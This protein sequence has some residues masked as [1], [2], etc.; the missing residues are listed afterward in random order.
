[1][2]NVDVLIVGAGPAGLFLATA[3]TRDGH[4]LFDFAYLE[5]C[6]IA[7]VIS[8]ATPDD[9]QFLVQLERDDDPLRVAMHTIARRC[10]FNPDRLREYQLALTVAC[11]GALK[12]Y[13]L[14]P[15]QKQR[16]YLTAAYL[17]QTL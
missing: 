8:P 6:L 3:L 5:A 10:L 9:R 7:Q 16:L 13:N 15:V 1:M 12:F 4:A 14:D 11:L 17:S 2:T